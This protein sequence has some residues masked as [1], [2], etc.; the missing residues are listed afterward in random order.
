MTA[1]GSVR[2][3][4][5]AARSARGR[6]RTRPDADPIPLPA[7]RKLAPAPAR[8]A[9][10]PLGSGPSPSL[11]THAFCRTHSQVFGL[12]R[13][14]RRPNRK[15]VSRKRFHVP[16]TVELRPR[17]CKT[18]RRSRRR[19]RTGGDQHEKRADQ[20]T[21]R[22]VSLRCGSIRGTHPGPTG[23]DLGSTRPPLSTDNVVVVATVSPRIERL[24][25]EIDG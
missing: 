12:G 4:Q 20:S 19:L 23:S 1:P 13:R 15:T 6:G 16:E 5:R 2:V 24:L 11:A 25:E 22:C 3:L 8:A 7:L 18:W 21:N 10:P 14:P 17:W 9:L